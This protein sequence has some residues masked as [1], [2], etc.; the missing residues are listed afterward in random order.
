M[1]SGKIFRG[2]NEIENQF[3]LDLEY[4]KTN[5]FSLNNLNI[6]IGARVGNMYACKLKCTFC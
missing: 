2:E 1:R 6:S 4:K 5:V 3:F